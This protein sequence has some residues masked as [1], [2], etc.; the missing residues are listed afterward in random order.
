M[1]VKGNILEKFQITSYNNNLEK[2]LEK[3]PF[4]IDTK[5]LLLSMLY[6]IENG[7]KDYS[8]IKAEEKTKTEFI[9]YIFDIIENK[10]N[11]IIIAEFDF[12]A[13]KILKQK[14]IKYLIDK[15]E[16]KIICYGNELL[17][18][19]CILKL[20][21]IDMLNNVEE[22]LI[23]NS[24][25]YALNIGYETDFVEVMRDFNGWSWNI[26]INEI[27][28]IEINLVYQLIK[29]L[30][31]KRFL[32]ELMDIVYRNEEINENEELIDI[33]LFME[34][35]ENEYDKEKIDEFI[36]LFIILSINLKLRDSKEEEAI[37][38]R[39]NNEY[40]KELE[41][42]ENKVKYIKDITE[43]K[44]K[45]LREIEN[46]DKSLN[47]TEILKE[48]YDKRNKKLAN[49]DKIFSLSHLVDILEKERLNY[50]SKINE[51]NYL[52]SPKGFL[53]RKKKIE[54]NVKFMQNLNIDIGEE[55]L[56]KKYNERIREQIIKFCTTFFDC[57]YAKIY[58]ANTKS[59][60]LEN[61][62]RL[63]YCLNLITDKNG[64]RLNEINKIKKVISK[65]EKILIDKAKEMSLVEEITKDE[66][67]NN[68]I[69]KKIFDIQIID[70]TNI[71]IKTKIE[72]EKLYIEYYDEDVLEEKIEIV[73]DHNV[74]LKKKAKL[75]K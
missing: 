13:G 68:R 47:N 40:K 10:C 49:K 25:I 29:I 14:N 45:Y 35:T 22:N 61:I 58:K 20:G 60:I 69:I 16:G 53:E 1:E 72:Q 3:K 18:L 74:K 32:E 26:S 43:N 31:G 15:N 11:N 12:E 6:K 33:N 73:T 46:I 7:Y 67:I 5:S 36:N 41:K 34:E 55:N 37:W 19:E 27:P 63:R 9:T 59:E 54:E 75:F 64:E 8:V 44:K 17:L 57:L 71:V 65:N 39:K 51:C 42:L 48:E 24:L 21:Q 62:Y 70:L 4:S 66:E 50:M 30:F 2:I 56:E 52:I 28:N 23:K 38:Q